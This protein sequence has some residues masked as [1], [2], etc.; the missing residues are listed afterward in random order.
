MIASTRQYIIA[1]LHVIGSMN[2]TAE[3]RPTIIKSEL[4]LVGFFCKSA[5][6]TANDCICSVGL[7]LSVTSYEHVG[8]RLA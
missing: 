8:L 3:E 1:A 4:S 7:K 5:C 2:E 6:T